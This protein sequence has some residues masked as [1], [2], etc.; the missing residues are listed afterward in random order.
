MGGRGVQAPHP[1]CATSQAK[2]RAN[3]SSSAAPFSSKRSES[4]KLWPV[5]AA[6]SGTAGAVRPATCGRRKT[7]LLLLVFSSPSTEWHDDGPAGAALGL[8]RGCA[9]ALLRA[10]LWAVRHSETKLFIYPNTKGKC[11][12]SSVSSM[13]RVLAC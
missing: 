4:T 9:R 3:F 13:A 8:A 12:D 10:A 2:P 1:R 5:A 6:G 7:A 11:I